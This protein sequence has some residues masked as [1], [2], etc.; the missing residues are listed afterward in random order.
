M[1]EKITNLPFPRF[2]LNTDYSIVLNEEGVSEDGE[3]LEAYTTKGKCIFS[4]K[5]K[6]IIDSQGKEIVL[7]AKVIVE[8]DIAPHLKTVSD[9]TITINDI[10][11]DIHSASRPRNPDGSIH[12][13]TFEVK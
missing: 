3:P 4:E 7:L 1:I 12:H 6:R 2:L 13:T 9:G 8:G 5:A 10:P 11:Y